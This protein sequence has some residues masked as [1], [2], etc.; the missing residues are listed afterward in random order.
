[1]VL[2]ALRSYGVFGNLE[3]SLELHQ[4][5]L[6]PFELYKDNSLDGMVRLCS[7]IGSSNLLQR[8]T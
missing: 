2:S 5:Q 3:K 4:Q 7:K 1:M 6:A 8:H